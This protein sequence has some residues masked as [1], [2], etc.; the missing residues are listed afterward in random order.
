MLFAGGTGGVVLFS[1]AA[2]RLSFR[3]KQCSARACTERD[4]VAGEESADDEEV[5]VC[6]RQPNTH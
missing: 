1:S 4:D 2:V 3:G 6:Q 5:M